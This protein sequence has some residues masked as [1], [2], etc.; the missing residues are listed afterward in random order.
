MLPVLHHEVGKYFAVKP[1]YFLENRYA[2]SKRGFSNRGSA[3]LSMT[4][5]E[6]GISPTAANNSGKVAA[7]IARF[8]E[9]VEHGR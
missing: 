3:S 7:Y 5:N 8:F 6:H 4:W 1:L 9:N 2:S